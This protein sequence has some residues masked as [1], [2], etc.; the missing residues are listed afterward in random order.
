MRSGRASSRPAESLRFR[1]PGHMRRHRHG[2][3]R[4]A[5]FAGIEGDRLGLRRAHGQSALLRWLGRRHQLRQDHPGHADGGS[6]RCDLPTIIVTGGPM[7][8]G[9]PEKS[10]LDL[11]SVFEALGEYKAGEDGPRAGG[12]RRGTVPARAQEL[13]RAVHG[14]HHG[15]P[16]RGPGTVPGRAAARAMADSRKKRE[17]ARESGRRIVELARQNDAPLDRDR[18]LVQERHKGRYGHRRLD[19]HRAC[20]FRRSPRSSGS[21][22]A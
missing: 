7:E 19:Q 4:H 8:H 22:S 17:I 2:A 5:V 18:G 3:C 9:D 1:R 15:L 13:R 20:I 21:I 11:Q 10:A 16:Y 6:G 14:E 12:A